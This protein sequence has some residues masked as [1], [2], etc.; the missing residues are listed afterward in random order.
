MLKKSK[1]ADLYLIVLSTVTF[2]VAP[3]LAVFGQTTPSPYSDQI[4]SPVRGLSAEEVDNLL[5]GRGAGYARMAELNNYP[6]PAHVL[7]LQDQLELSP[8]QIQAI[9][10]I[11]QRMNTKAK[12]IG[13][14]IVEQEQALSVAFA[15]NTITSTALQTHIQAL[16][17]LYGE[18]RL[19]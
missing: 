13:Q 17:E 4:P 12:E 10:T 6:G 14:T 9:E 3:H 19:T 5:N 1:I 15:S 8:E 11:F 7:E 16:A 18:L 2:A